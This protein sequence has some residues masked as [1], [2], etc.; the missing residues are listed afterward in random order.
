MR[1]G[2]TYGVGGFA[3]IEARDN[4]ESSSAGGTDTNTRS[5]GGRMGGSN[6]ADAGAGVAEGGEVRGVRFSFF[7]AAGGIVMGMEDGGKG[8]GACLS[9]EVA[10]VMGADA[11]DVAASPL[12]IGI[13]NLSDSN[14]GIS[15][16]TGGDVGTEG[17]NGFSLFWRGNG[18]GATAALLAGRG[19]ISLTGEL[20][21]EPGA[22]GLATVRGPME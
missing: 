13:E 14:F 9:L 12:E 21:A 3:M 7:G 8:C 10:R 11:L 6:G 17:G 2:S 5:V 18:A 20:S 1:L 4:G 22:S 16:K 15:N 19:D